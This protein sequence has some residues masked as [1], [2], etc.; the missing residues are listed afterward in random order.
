MPAL[1]LYFRIMATKWP[2]ASCNISVSLQ[3]LFRLAT[4]YL[5][6]MLLKNRSMKKT[7]QNKPSP[8]CDSD[9]NLCV[10]ELSRGYH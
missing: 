7:P 10:S 5:C 2:I 6:C 1:L 4:F 8:P 9:F 3:V